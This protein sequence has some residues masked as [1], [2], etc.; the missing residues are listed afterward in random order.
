MN[1]SAYDLIGAPFWQVCL[2]ENP[3]SHFEFDSSAEFRYLGTEKFLP[4]THEKTRPLKI[5]LE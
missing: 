3:Q 4:R 2:R 5:K 1:A